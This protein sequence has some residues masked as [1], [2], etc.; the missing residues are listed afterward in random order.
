MQKLYWKIFIWFWVAT[1]LTI[2][3]TALLSSKLT[4]HST[5]RL[6]RAIVSSI[7]S[8]AVI[9]L[10]HDQLEQ[11]HEWGNAL[12]KDLGIQFIIQTVNKNKPLSHNYDPELQQMLHKLRQQIPPYRN[13]R[14]LP[15]MISA[16][17]EDKKGVQ[18]RLIIKFPKHI[19]EKFNWSWPDITFKLIIAFLISGLICY[20]LSL[21]LSRPIRILQRAARRLGRG[22][23]TT[24]VG[25]ELYTRKD[26]IAELAF[27][28]DDMASRLQTLMQTRQQLLHDISHELRSPLARLSVAL[29]IARKKDNDTMNT[30]LARIE[31][32]C[33][34]LNELIGKILSF[35]SLNVKEEDSHF[36]DINI[37]TLLEHIIDD[38]HYEAQCKHA[39]IKLSAE[40]D[41]IV[42]ANQT[43]LKSAIENIIRNAVRYSPDGTDIDITL[44]QDHGNI[45][46]T[47]NDGGPGIPD[48]KME[49]IF[50]PFFRVDSSR[51][52]KT[53]GYGLGL[54]IAKKAIALHQG[55]IM[56][57]NRVSGGLSVMISLPNFRGK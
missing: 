10:G 43:S 39:Q 12:N 14:D 45:K 32:E 3:A 5:N 53:G 49:K 7:Y 24:R 48:N 40:D 38:A 6:D 17:I 50:E 18:H 31:K 57:E 9:M 15:Y 44:V 34:N 11:L 20:L 19:T 33:D 23:L 30:E 1:I 2:I 51:T 35:A 52:S 41:F 28:F 29:E 25:K 22:E 55:K 42:R 27:E 21:Y 54:A 16:P 56:A 46:I 37:K 8:G 13:M 36:T 47:V 26:E 4:Q